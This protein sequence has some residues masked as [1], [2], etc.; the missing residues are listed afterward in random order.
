MK[1]FHLSNQSGLTLVELLITISLIGIFA[2]VAILGFQSMR[3]SYE[4]MDVLTVFANDISL[5]RLKSVTEGGRGI[6]VVDSGANSYSFGYDYLFP[7]YSTVPPIIY[8]PT[9]YEFTT[10]LPDGFEISIVL[11]GSAPAVHTPV[12]FDSKGRVIDEFGVLRSHTI[13]LTKDGV[14]YRTAVLS[15]GGVLTFNE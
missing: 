4:R 7:D 2:G 3:E 8:D 6:L 1:E 14:A 15:P 12:I 11:E 9:G 10:E 13:T 5:A